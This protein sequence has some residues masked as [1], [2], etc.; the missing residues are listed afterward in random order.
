M[1]EYSV[2]GERPTKEVSFSLSL[3]LS[4]SNNLQFFG[5]NVDKGCFVCPPTPSCCWNCC[6]SWSK[7]IRHLV[8]RKMDAIS[9]SVGSEE[10]LSLLLLDDDVPFACE[11]P[12]MMMKIL[13]LS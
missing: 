1:S 13:W 5:L 4:L 6:S 7:M 2:S 9:L 11:F 3:S 12:M 10:V 8:D